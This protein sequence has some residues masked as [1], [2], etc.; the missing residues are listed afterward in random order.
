[1]F[2]KNIVNILFGDF[3]NKR[4]NRLNRYES[5][6]NSLYKHHNQ[7]PNEIIDFLLYQAKLNRIRTEKFECDNIFD[8]KENISKNL[9]TIDSDLNDID[10]I[11]TSNNVCYSLSE[12]LEQ[13]KN[14]F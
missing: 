12:Y 11:I 4:N 13:N 2:I 1:M 14:R 8:F 6:L 5:Q 10:N 7:C 9:S 3:I